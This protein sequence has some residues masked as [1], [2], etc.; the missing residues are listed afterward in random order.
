MAQEFEQPI[1][2][3]WEKNTV[4]FWFDVQEVNN[5]KLQLVIQEKIEKKLTLK[6]KEI[7]FVIKTEHSHGNADGLTEGY[8]NQ[9]PIFTSWKKLRTWCNAQVDEKFH[10]KNMGDDDYLVRHVVRNG[11]GRFTDKF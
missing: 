7:Y 1:Y 4:R 11:C 10:W 2:I 5:D 3:Y 8:I 9:S 6:Q